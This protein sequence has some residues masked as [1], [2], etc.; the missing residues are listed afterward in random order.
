M[1]MAQE[2]ARRLCSLKRNAALQVSRTVVAFNLSARVAMPTPVFLQRPRRAMFLQHMPLRY[3][4]VRS[5]QQAPIILQGWM[6]GLAKNA[7]GY[8]GS[9]ARQ[10]Q[11]GRPHTRR[12]FL[13]F[14]SHQDGTLS[15]SLLGLLNRRVCRSILPLFWHCL[16]TLAL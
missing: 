9:L 11:V 16:R 4:P 8:R 10:Q 13:S 2:I 15:P 6:V 12:L 7:L 5:L 1:I 14:R 3:V